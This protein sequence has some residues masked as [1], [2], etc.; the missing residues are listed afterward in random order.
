MYVITFD[1]ESDWHA[2]INIFKATQ[3]PN[4]SSPVRQQWI[5]PGRDGIR[6]GLLLKW[7][8]V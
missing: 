3:A 5:L 4:Q 7:R 2:K 8:N 1:D 6:N